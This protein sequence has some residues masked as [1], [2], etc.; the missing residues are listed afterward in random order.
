MS[1]GHRGICPPPLLLFSRLFL[2]HLLFLLLF[3][4]L[5]VARRAGRHLPLRPRLLPGGGGRSARGAARR[6]QPPLATCVSSWDNATRPA[7]P[8]YLPGRR[9]RSA[10]FSSGSPPSRLQSSM[11]KVPGAWR[12][13]QR[14]QLRLPQGRHLPLPAQPRA[15]RTAR[16]VPSEVAALLLAAH[17]GHQPVAQV[18]L[19]LLGGLQFAQPNWFCA[20]LPPWRQEPNKVRNPASES[21]GLPSAEGSPKWHSLKPEL[22]ICLDSEH[23][24]LYA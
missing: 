3:P 14:L 21:P 20:P 4:A 11:L 15:V 5:L 23:Y 17:R 7:E 24:P 18:V 16:G 10:P 19:S 22:L 13:H 6:R 8:L 12:C 9:S 2:V 1:L